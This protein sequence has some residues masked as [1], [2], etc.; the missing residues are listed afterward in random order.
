MNRSEWLTDDLLEGVF[1]D[2]ATRGS[3]EGLR[4]EVVSATAAVGQRGVWRLRLAN[5]L[6]APMPRPALLAVLL[7]AALLGVA[8]AIALAGRQPPSPFNIGSL[9]FVRDGDVYLANPDGSDARVVLHENG[10]VFSTV[11]WSRDGS[12]LAVDGESGVVVLDAVSGAPA[13]VGGHNPAWSPDGRELAVLVVSPGDV[14][15]NSLRILDPA[16]RAVRAEFPF[17]A[18]NGLA[19]S[20]NGRWIAA[21]GDCTGAL[22]PAGVTSAANSVIRID[23][24]TGD[25]I[26]VDGRS[27]HLDAERQVAWSPDSGHVAYIRWGMDATRT[28]CDDLLLCTKD[29]IVAD[30]DGSNAVRVNEQHGRAD[31]PRWSPD[32]QWIAFRDGSH[33]T[34]QHPDGA[35]GRSIVDRP[36]LGFSWGPGS[37]R[38]WFTQEGPGGVAPV[39]E[40]SLDG[41]VRPL[42]V[43]IDGGWVFGGTGL[44]FDFQVRAAGQSEPSLAVGAPIT[45]VATLDVETPVPAA[46][47]DPSSRWSRLLTESTDLCQLLSVDSGSGAPTTIADLCTPPPTQGSSGSWSPTGTAYAIVRDGRLSIIYPDGRVGLDMDDLAGINGVTWS[48]DG[49]WLGAT[50]TSTYLLRPDGSGLRELPS[51]FLSWSPDGQKLAVSGTD[52]TLLIGPS[53][54]VGLTPIGTFP[55][56]T[57]WSP[58]GSRFGFVRDGDFWTASID[59][60]DLLNVTRLQLGGASGGTWSPDG[61]WVAVTANHGLW[62]VRPDGSERRWL[63]FGTGQFTYDAVWSPDSLRFAMS[64][65]EQSTEPSQRVHTYIVSAGGAPTIQ[66]DETWGPSWSPDG[67]FLVATDVPDADTS[68]QGSIVLLNADGS[69]QRVLPTHSLGNRPVWLP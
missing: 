56:P 29:V 3:L 60:T 69:G 14:T 47:A 57:T 66:V 59:G 32:G 18:F 51:N 19:W 44:A 23:V 58:D 10:V 28:N 50:G 20:P 12:R 43:S 27:G 21:T 26:Q 38:I 46:A 55:S 36:V 35:A 33:I 42:G 1:Q 15:S 39:W 13:F 64:A 8:L 41:D 16:T 6:P 65:Y 67:R 25:V 37:D 49:T 61:R 30:A 52:G 63:D 45:P 53:S 48:P 17:V 7:L 24:Q 4:A 62:L 2:R 34:I 54:G 9:A 31:Q 22:C 5:L 11:T 68:A 40:A